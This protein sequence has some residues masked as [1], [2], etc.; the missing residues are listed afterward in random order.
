MGPG[1]AHEPVLRQRCQCNLDII[2]GHAQEPGD[3]VRRVVVR[4]IAKAPEHT[5]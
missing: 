1:L 2:R 4:M 5:A 3:V